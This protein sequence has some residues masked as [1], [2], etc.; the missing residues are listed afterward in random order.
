V[1]R[2]AW[3]RELVAAIA[4][5]LALVAAYWKLALPGPRYVWFDHY[6]MCQLELP[7]LNFI[8]RTIHQGHFP[9]WD[10]HIWAGLPVLGAGQ[11]GAAYPL[12]LL[13][14]ALPLSGGIIPVATLNWLFLTMHFAAA[15]FFYLL[16]RD[17]ELSRIASVVGAISFSCGGYFGGAPWLDI[18]NGICWTPVIFLFA[19][20]LWRDRAAFPS[21]VLLGVAVGFS[22]LSG[23]HEIPMINC[24]AVVLG[25]LG[26]AAYRSVKSR[27][28][29]IGLLAW[30]A[31]ALILGAAISAV[32]TVPL[33]E[34][35]H[36]AKRW[37]GA[38][39][40]I[41]WNQKVPYTAIAQYS[42]PWRGVA[43]LLSPSA[44]PESHTTAFVGLTIAVLALL[45]AVYRW[46]HPAVRAAV[47]L[48]FGGLIYALGASTPV[49]KLLYTAL[50]ML[51]KARNPV[52]GL[53]LVAFAVSWLAA[54]GTQ[55]FLAGES[56]VRRA[57]LPVILVLAGALVLVHS[58][59]LLIEM[60][61]MLPS[62][63]I[64]KGLIAAVFLSLLALWKVPS[65]F[66]RRVSGVVLVVLVLMELSAVTRLRMA[67][68]DKAH[69]VCA[70]A[71][72]DRLDVAERLRNETGLGRITVDR[73]SVMTS[74]GD[75]YGFDQLGSFV[76]AAPANILSLEVYNT[77]TQ[78]L[79]G[80]THYVG[81]AAPPEG[82]SLVATFNDG[83]RLFRTPS[84]M[85]RAWIAHTTLRAKDASELR[86][87][88]Q[89]GAS[90]LTGTA[91]TLG[92][93][94][95]LEPRAGAES[96]NWWRPG[97]DRV[98]IDCAL[99]SRGLVVLSDVNYPG[100]IARLD[101]VPSPIY[102]AYGALRSVVAPPGT[103]RIEMRYEPAP[104]RLGLALTLAGALASFLLL[105]FSLHPHTSSSI[106]M[107]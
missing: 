68:F 106:M 75:L 41:G 101:G 88:V 13:F 43:G 74:L 3:R 64:L 103:H 59:G 32:Q 39:E 27:R 14:A 38:P 24:Y 102:E 63:Y 86:R 8:A 9:L 84:A 100:W 26:V 90:D 69:T 18:G 80:V 50:P 58:S 12:N 10:P 62:H 95:K 105:L 97:P 15:W 51:D 66:G 92:E 20:R 85:P 56:R 52:R 40:A 34:F 11:P 82:G 33:Y 2:A 31:L 30:V 17:Q 23:H 54:F 99:R 83:L 72:V 91:I 44:T 77:R 107:L 89:D 28:G 4:L 16:C 42:L 71:L 93:I 35:G 81:N 7:R 53:F 5:L 94:P 104:L 36:L 48:A 22:W 25:S 78:A 70:T 67:A 45:G 37:V 49:H 29:A 61:P 6:D 65:A 55:A 21:A 57:A 19:M 47:Y 46:R 96:V 76:A 73:E 87:L 79:L 1:T 60:Y 98:E